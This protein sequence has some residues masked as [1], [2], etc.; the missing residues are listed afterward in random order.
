MG[1]C[2]WPHIQ[3]EWGEEGQVASAEV[4]TPQKQSRAHRSKCL[5]EL[6]QCGLGKS[7][8][9]VIIVTSSGSVVPRFIQLSVAPLKSP[10]QNGSSLKSAQNAFVMF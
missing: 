6:C 10:R 4:D 9:I 8:R 3:E 1:M 5:W 2:F 7:F